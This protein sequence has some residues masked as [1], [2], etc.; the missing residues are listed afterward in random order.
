LIHALLEIN[1]TSTTLIE[2][3]T[4]GN[5]QIVGIV[6]MIQEIGNKTKIINDIVFQ[7]KLL[8]FNASVEAARAG[9]QG[10]GFAVVASEVGSLA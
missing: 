3:V 8:S 7:T 4:D 5:Q 9:E 10:K 6:G 1:T 2:K